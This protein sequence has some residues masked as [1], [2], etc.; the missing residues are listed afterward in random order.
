[1]RTLSNKSVEVLVVW[2]FDSEV[3]SADVVDGLVVNHET[4]VGMF[5]SGVSGQD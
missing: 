2:S 1:M 4:A 3:T 5:E